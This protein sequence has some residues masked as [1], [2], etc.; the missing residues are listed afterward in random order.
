MT[1]GNG[2][3]V[4][5]PPGTY[6]VKVTAADVSPDQDGTHLRETYLSVILAEGEIA[7]VG[8]L[9]PE[10]ATPPED[11]SRFF[12]VPF[13]AGTVGFADAKAARR[14][15]KDDPDQLDELTDKWIGLLETPDHLGEGATNVPLPLAHGAEN[16]IITRSGWGD[17]LY[18]V[19]GT[20]D[21]TGRLMGV[22]IDLL[23]DEPEGDEPG[24]DEPAEV[25]VIISGPQFDAAI[26]RFASLSTAAAAGVRLL[27]LVAGFSTGQLGATATTWVFGILSGLDLAALIL[28][29]AGLVI[30]R[31]SRAWAAL[32]LGWLGLLAAFGWTLG[33]GVMVILDDDANR[34]PLWLEPSTSSIHFILTAAIIGA[35]ALSSL[36]FARRAG[37]ATIP[38]AGAS[39]APPLTTQ[40]ARLDPAGSLTSRVCEKRT[41]SPGANIAKTGGMVATRPMATRTSAMTSALMTSKCFVRSAKCSP[42]QD[43]SQTITVKTALPERVPTPALRVA[44][45]LKP[46]LASARI[47]KRPSMKTPIPPARIAA[48]TG[49]S[50]FS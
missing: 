6:P 16:L 8:H 47:V 26:M 44:R 48:A 7:Q 28:V 3:L 39:T 42:V 9:T 17:G 1:L 14:A 15:A 20:Y 18:P 43:A 12:G 46:A 38:V 49:P 32:V 23:V 40:P 27:A 11:A 25:A 4:T 50:G 37:C 30:A 21:A 33:Q 31:R 36:L 29:L 13:D 24:A 35:F 45:A 5:V 2:F 10:G 22:H 41:Y 19:L 34:T